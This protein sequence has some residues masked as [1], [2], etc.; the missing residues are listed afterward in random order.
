[1]RSAAAGIDAALVSKTA[2]SRQLGVMGSTP[3]VP[4]VLPPA[5]VVRLLS[6]KILVSGGSARVPIAWHKGPA[7]GRSS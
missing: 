2:S 6:A 1:M 5:P 3:S 7:P 4:A